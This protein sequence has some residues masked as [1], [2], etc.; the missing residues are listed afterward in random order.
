MGYIIADEATSAL[1][2]ILTACFKSKNPSIEAH[3]LKN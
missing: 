1:V 2:L 3:Q